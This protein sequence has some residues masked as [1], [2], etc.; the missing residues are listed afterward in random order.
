[1]SSYILL[2]VLIIGIVVGFAGGYFYAKKKYRFT[3]EDALNFC[4][5][6]PVNAYPISYD[7]IYDFTSVRDENIAKEDKDER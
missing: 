7:D 5:R 3:V 2:L 1:M 6:H 4:S